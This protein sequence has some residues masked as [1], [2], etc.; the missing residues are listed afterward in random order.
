MPLN[1]VCF[2]YVGDRKAESNGDA[3]NREVLMR[4]QERGIAAPSSTVL[5]GRFAMRVA[6][7]NHRSTRADFDALVNAV[8][9]IGRE[10]T[11]GG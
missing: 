6:I 1:V 9:A 8:L 7:T 10:V 4:I 11:R 3:I 5:D 2:R